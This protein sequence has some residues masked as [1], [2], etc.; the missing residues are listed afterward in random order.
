MAKT[1]NVVAIAKTLLD[2][3]GT[4]SNRARLLTQEL[5]HIYEET[6]NPA[7]L[8]MAKAA[9]TLTEYCEDQREIAFTEWLK[10][11]EE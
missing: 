11:K 9:E 2:R 8:K 10:T 7:D 6:G 1:K 5:V 4:A 3:R